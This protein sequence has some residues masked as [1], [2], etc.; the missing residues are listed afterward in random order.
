[1]SQITHATEEWR[2]VPGHPGYDVS[3]HG[4]VR[5]YRRRHGLVAEPRLLSPVVGK[6]GYPHVAVTGRRHVT[7]HTL[8]L[9]TFVGP[10]PA[11]MECR[12][13][14]GNRLNPRLDNLRWGTRSEN[15]DDRRKHGTSNDGERAGAARLSNTQVQEVRSS[16]T[17]IRVLAARFGVS[18][19]T[20]SRI[21]SGHRW[22]QLEG[23]PPM[24]YGRGKKV[25]EDQVRAIRSSHLT[26]VKLA[27]IYNVSD[28]TINNIR[29]RK[30]WKH[31]P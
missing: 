3:S 28:V 5:S 20:I 1:M 13:L 15:Y 22:R 16:D 21:R 12:H 26:Q 30:T 8:V 29:T 27:A 11:N 23:A 24:R 14:D 17:P 4:R 19:N 6:T 10:R 25:T 31:V 9:T 18:E 2:P 7:V